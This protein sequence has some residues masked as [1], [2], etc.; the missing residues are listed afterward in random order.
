MAEYSVLTY[1]TFILSK[2]DSSVS[3]L[4]KM[5]N[6]S[7]SMYQTSAGSL[8]RVFKVFAVTGNFVPLLHLIK[9]L[10]KIRQ[11]LYL[12]EAL[13]SNDIVYLHMHS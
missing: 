7:S 8:L 2:C 5:L 4:L 12:H 13:P 11:N 10:K 1:L 9:F 6:F 3:S